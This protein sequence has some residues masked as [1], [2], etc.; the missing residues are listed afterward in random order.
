MTLVV[1]PRQILVDANGAPRIGAKMR[2]YNA[3]TT[4]ERTAYTTKDY[5]IVLSQPIESV[6]SGLFPT[7]YV[8]PSGGDYKLVVADADDVPLYTVD[9]IPAQI[10]SGDLDLTS[11]NTSSTSTPLIASLNRTD[12]EIAVPVVSINYTY[13]PLDQLRYLPDITGAS[14]S[15]NS[16]NAAIDTAEA[17][18]NNTVTLAEGQTRYDSTVTIHQGVALIGKGSQGSTQGYGTNLMHNSASDFLVWDGNGAAN[19]GTG[20][21]LRNALILKSS[22]L[23]GGDAVK[24]IATDDDHRPGEMFFENVLIYGSGTGLWGRG[25]V[26]DG[27]ACDTPGSAGVRHVHVNKLRVADCTENLKYVHL[28][29]AVHFSA[30]ALSID[31]GDGTGTPGMTIEGDADNIGM[32]NSIISGELEVNGSAAIDVN[33]HGKISTVDI[34][35]VSVDGTVVGSFADLTNASL[36]VR[37]VSSRADAFAAYLSAATAN[38]KTGDGTDYNIICDTEIYDRNSC[39]D[40]TT[41]I[42]TAKCAGIHEVHAY[43]TYANLG[44][45]HV[46]STSGVVHMDAASATIR[47]YKPGGG[48]N[49]Y[50]MAAGGAGGECTRVLVIPIEMLEGEKLR[51]VADVAGSTKTVGIKGGNLGTIHTY[52]AAKLLA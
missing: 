4:T 22:G 34:N 35:N 20:G 8:N 10:S 47:A 7:V 19:A 25:F 27:T 45:G 16:L 51:L 50:A 6:G 38:D 40:H 17:G 2:V 39:Y 23:S 37:I 52:F 11:L 12:A 9:N 18:N 13:Q 3:G 1:L 48:V 31:Q 43:W 41:G 28:N 44:S 26:V 32:V 46:T 5:N 36:A 29:Q 15:A 49:P 30:V 14:N 24:A 21:G 33:V 42:Y